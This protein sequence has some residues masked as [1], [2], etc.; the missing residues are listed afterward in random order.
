MYPILSFRFIHCPDSLYFYT[1]YYLFVL[2]TVRIHYII[3]TT[4]NILPVS[5]NNEVVHKKLMV[6]RI[7]FTRCPTLQL[8]DT[9]C[10]YARSQNCEKRLS[11]LSHLSVRLSVCARGTTRLQLV[12]CSWNLTFDYFL[13]ICR[14]NSRFIKIG[15]K[16]RVL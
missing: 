7:S 10:F 9:L 11:A 16:W 14:E 13:K 5:W 12:G 1:Q 3:I 4:K 6:T 2:S 8:K 15:Q